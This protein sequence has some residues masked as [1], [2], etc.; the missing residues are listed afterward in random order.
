MKMTRDSSE[1]RHIYINYL[2]NNI[3]RRQ[4][5]ESKSLKSHIYVF[6]TVF[7]ILCS[8]VLHQIKGL[9]PFILYVFTIKCGYFQHFPDVNILKRVK[10]CSIASYI[11]HFDLYIKFFAFIEWLSH[12]TQNANHQEPYTSR[13]GVKTFYSSDVCLKNVFLVLRPC[14]LYTKQTGVNVKRQQL[15]DSL[16]LIHNVIRAI[17]I[18]KLLLIK[19]VVTA[20]VCC[21][22][23]VKLLHPSDRSGCRNQR[24]PRMPRFDP[25]TDWY[26]K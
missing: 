12:I 17:A 24:R 16:L 18:F 3:L 20:C 2:T 10:F 5:E 7:R 1:Y 23:R 25:T 15:I 6:N 9:I 26:T 4:M 14:F 13:A 8:T 19:H 11:T 22:L 21:D